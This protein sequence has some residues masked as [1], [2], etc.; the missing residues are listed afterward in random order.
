MAREAASEAGITAEFVKV[1]DM[2]QILEYDL[3]S[4]PGLMVNGKVVA[5]G[6]IPTTAELQGWLT[7]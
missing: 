1:T 7:A 6:R 3:L 5:S 2:G 4:T